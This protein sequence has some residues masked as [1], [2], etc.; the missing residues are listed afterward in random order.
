MSIELKMLPLAAEPVRPLSC[1]VVTDA[2][3]AEALRP[4]WSDLLE[5]AERSELTQSPEW[6][7]TWWSVFG[8]LHGR[9]MRLGVFHEGDRLVGLA[10][11]LNRRHWYRGL[12]PFRRLELLASGEPAEHGIYSNHLGIL[13]ERGAEARVADRLAQGIRAGAF[14]T[15]D[16]VVLTMMSG[17]TVMPDHLANAFRTQRLATELTTIAQAPYVLLPATW[18][19]Y[20]SSLSSDHRYHVRRSLKTFEKWS[21]GTTRLECLTAPADVER[22]KKVLIDLHQARWA[23]DGQTGVFRSEWFLRFHDQIMA[24]LASRGALEISL[25]HARGEPVAALYCMTWGDKVYYYQMGRRADLPNHLRP[26]TVILALAI[27]CAIEQGRREFDMLADDAIYKRQLA[28]HARPLV[29]VRAA[30][31]SFVETARRL[32]IHCLAGLRRL[33]EPAAK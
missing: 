1:A 22:G 13:A 6:L 32:G 33:R 15:W 3:E 17:D 4:E 10:P 23:E 5:R 19:A 11:L 20:L 27:Q 18:E 30:R 8:N 21:E 9:T 7:R 25:L 29:Q 24:L 28:Q 16:E 12:L 2:A 31:T 26:G 14:G